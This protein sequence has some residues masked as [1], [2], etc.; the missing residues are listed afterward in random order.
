[1]G[2]VLAHLKVRSGADLGRRFFWG[3]FCC[4]FFAGGSPI[5]WGAIGGPIDNCPKGRFHVSC[6]PPSGHSEPTA[7]CRT[8]RVAETWR[9]ARGERARW[10]KCKRVTKWLTS[11]ALSAATA[12]NVGMPDYL[13]SLL[14]QTR[15]TSLHGPFLGSS[16][17]PFQQSAAVFDT[18]CG[19]HLKP[20]SDPQQVT[21][22]SD[23]SLQSV[24]TAR[25]LH[26]LQACPRPAGSK[27]SSRARQVKQTMKDTTCRKQT[28]QK[29]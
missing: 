11:D 22:G 3:V 14:A 23:G 27:S 7:A 15:R 10:G 29:H 24:P 6:P 25:P 8:P 19:G 4:C 28:G 12:L 9:R 16:A 5:P 2:A 13:G 17:L 21:D 18:P 26:K 1:M 20:C